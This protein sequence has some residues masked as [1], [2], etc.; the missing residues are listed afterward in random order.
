M[1]VAQLTW[2]R[3]LQNSKQLFVHPLRPQLVSNRS[4]WTGTSSSH[5]LAGT[6]T[7]MADSR[8]TSTIRLLFCGP[9]SVGSGRGL[10]SL[11]SIM[12]RPRGAMQ[13]RFRHGVQG[14][15]GSRAC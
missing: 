1:W 12:S 6:S 9:T 2:A 7:P 3:S 10:G 15:A 8:R 14:P 4:C 13:L 11:F 5:S